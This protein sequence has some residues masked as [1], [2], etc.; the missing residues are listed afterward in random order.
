[1]L[2]DSTFTMTNCPC[3]SGR[4]SNLSRAARSS[5]YRS[6]NGLAEAT[7]PA[8]FFV[9]VHFYDPHDPTIHP[10]PTDQ[11]LE[12]TSIGEIAYSDEQ[13]GRLLDF[14][15]QSKLRSGTLVWSSA[16]MVKD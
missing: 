4:Q 11:L 3:R 16:I 6:G 15:E 2:K 14:L 13:V 7:A 1:M 12:W 5:H 9:W 8:K 10:S